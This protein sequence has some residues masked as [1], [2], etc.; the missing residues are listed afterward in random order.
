[1][2]NR[3]LSLLLA[4]CV[5]VGHVSLAHAVC[6]QYWD[7]VC[8]VNGVTYTNAGCAADA[9]V[10]VAY[11]G[12][13]GLPY[14]TVSANTLF[15]GGSASCQSPVPAGGSS[16]CTISV[17]TD[18][19]LDTFQVNGVEKISGVINNNYTIT[20]I[21]AN[22]T[23]FYS[24]SAN[25]YTVSTTPDVHLCGN[26][27]CQQPVSYG[28]SSLCTISHDNAQC[29]GYVLSA[30]LVNG[31][32]KLSSVSNDQYT[33]TN[34][35]ANQT[36]AFDFA[37][38]PISY[39]ITGFSDAGGSVSCDTP[40]FVNNSSQCTVSPAAGYHLGGFL[41][42]GVDKKDGVNNNT[43]TVTNVQ[44]EQTITGTFVTNTPPGAPALGT[45]WAGNAQATQAFTA[46]GDSGGLP[47][48]SYTVTAN[49]GG[50]TA[51]GTSSP[52]TVTGLTNGTYYT[53]TVVATNALGDGP[54]SSAS[55]PLLVYD[56][57]GNDYDVDLVL[58]T[59]DN[60]PLIANLDQLDNDQDGRG[61]AC[62]PQP[63]VATEWK[64]TDSDGV[65]DNA[66]SC[67][68]TANPSQA[69][70]DRDAIGDAC[71]GDSAP[72]FG[73]VLDAPHNQ[74]HGVACSDCHSYSM[75]WQHSPIQST[76]SAY[77]LRTDAICLK[78][79]GLGLGAITAVH[80]SAAMGTAHNPALGEWSSKCVDCHRPHKQP[81]IEWRGSE[82]A[83]LYL[84]KGTIVDGITVT[85]GQTTFNFQLLDPANPDHPE[86]NDPTRWS[87][88]TNRE[89]ASGLILVE[90]L[91]TALNTYEVVAATATTIT[92]KGGLS[93]TAAGR[94]FGLIYGQ[95]ITALAPG[96]QSVKFFDPNL[97][98]DSG[99]IGGFADPVNTTAP[100]GICQVCHTTTQHW[101]S[102]GTGNTHAGNTVCTT[103]HNPRQGFKM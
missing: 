89:P 99:A 100:Q 7:P 79:H 67:V 75:W 21:Q 19:H 15:A 11:S 37:P 13:C 10:T 84:V 69:D 88:K 61:D 101:K 55:A 95:M 76:D 40:V 1:M 26:V 53:F 12:E 91:S 28:G 102:D 72:N 44:G 42:N 4:T 52:L 97:T 81:Q 25:T 94:S 54:A 29:P 85:G 93:P 45:T 24:M 83:A 16:L 56:P 65:G 59:V 63:L 92:I 46:P 103:C 2:T 39:S 82:S 30:F 38:P 62:D 18:Y 34:I 33:I 96:G 20:N 17:W 70:A 36:V 6:S 23:V 50:L 35:Q 9:G 78:C 3:L 87:N 90:E 58:N 80:S 73:S 43:Y 86:W 8:G 48:T 22:Q 77:G 60:C 66:D 5:F 51:T 98:Y 14:Y 68:T 64:D 27:S 71:D 49:P 41:V 47:I 31:V 74:S 57:Q 32:D